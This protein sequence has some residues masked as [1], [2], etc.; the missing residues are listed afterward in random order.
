MFAICEEEVVATKTTNP[1]F[2]D[3]MRAAYE[4]AV[5]ESTDTNTKVGA[6]II[7][8]DGG[9]LVSGANAF[10][11]P[12]MAALP[13]NHMRPRKYRIIEHAE[14][15]AIYKAAMLGIPLDGRTMVCPW[16][17]CSDCARGIV[18]SGIRSVIAHQ[19]VFNL[20]PDRWR[21]EVDLG[22]EILESGGVSYTLFDGEIGNV[23]NVFDG[24]VWYP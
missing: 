22:I 24:E 18:L 7:D 9:V 16:A 15:V 4:V 17:C 19:Q 12:S 3:L 20:I 13:E 11:D 2:R 23:K 8:N 10:I 5:R 14:R 1:V 6:V 21:E